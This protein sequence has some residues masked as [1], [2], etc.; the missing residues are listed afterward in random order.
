MQKTAL[1]FGLVILTA[2]TPAL[3]RADAYRHGAHY[4]PY[5]GHHYRPY[6][7]PAYTHQH[8]D[9]YY[10]HRYYQRDYW[11]AW[12][13]GLMAGAVVT[14]LLYPPPARTVVYAQPAPVVVASNVAPAVVPALPA[15]SPGTVSV[16][17][18]ALNVRSGPGLN[19]AITAYV[20][21]G[22]VL[23]VSDTAPGWL[24]VRTPA[25]HTGWVMAQYTRA[26]TPA[27]G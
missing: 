10:H 6:R 22:A 7:H 21:M 23:T 8:Y 13:L 16:S 17:V 1:L 20:R 27:A 3:A 12:G 26:L 19:H 15:A 18:G 24:Y 11:A 5:Y 4:R 14:Q 25:G 9:R 2:L